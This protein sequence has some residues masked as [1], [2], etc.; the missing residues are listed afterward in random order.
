MPQPHSPPSNQLIHGDNL[1]V[2]KA[3]QTSHLE[4]VQCLILDPPKSS[5]NKRSSLAEFE[6]AL[7]GCLSLAVPLLRASGVAFLHC[8][9]RHLIVARQCAER[10]FGADNLLNTVILKTSEPSGLRSANASLFSQTEYLLVFA[11]NR[12]EFTYYPQ[13]TKAAYDPCYRSVVVN[14]EEPMET[15][16]VESFPRFMAKSMGYR[17][18]RAARADLG[19]LFEKRLGDYALAHPDAVFQSTRVNTRAGDEI[20]RLAR[21]SARR[22]KG[23]FKLERDGAPD[24][25][26]RGGR[27]MTFYRTRVRRLDG[28]DQPSKMLT[29]L[30]TDVSF[31]GVGYEGQTPFADGKKPERL[32]QRILAMCTRPGDLVLDPFGG[33]GTTAAVA[34]KLGRRWTLIER[35]RK[36]VN[37]L[38]LPRLSAV[39]SGA[40]QTGLNKVMETHT[41]GR[42]EVCK[43]TRKQLVCVDTVVGGA[44]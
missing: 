42:F 23:V 5:V 8:D 24:V 7:D 11:R 10:H 3:L 32:V 26:L 30:W 4:Q 38:I 1:K 17:S 13:Y 14:S 20:K 21:Q 18:V 36:H 37:K 2:L 35:E 25:Y 29:N 31:H 43:V 22:P 41:G 40:D 44:S 12:R 28:A 34:E 16:R 19:V 9:D 33:S 6:A 39:V 15:W 27:Q